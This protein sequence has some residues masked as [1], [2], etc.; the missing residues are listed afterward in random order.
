[1]LYTIEEII[2]WASVLLLVSIIG[3]KI[4]IRF[5]IPAIL[6]F[7]IIGMLMGS[8]GPGGIP[9]D[10]PFVAEFLG[11]IALAY[12][13]FAGALSINWKSIKPVL[14]SGISLSTLAVLVTAVL[15]GAI[16]C[17]LFKLSLLKGLLL[18]AI[19]SSTDVAAVFSILRS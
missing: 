2:F 5:G 12:I 3:S 15:T 19:V 18:G 17:V 16:T 7:L 11:V 6:F 1:M 4:T 9:F 8:D 10:D 13:I 14:W